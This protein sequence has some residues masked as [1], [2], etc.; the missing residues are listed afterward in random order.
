MAMSQAPQA[1][2]IVGNI[3]SFAAPPPPSLGSI[4]GQE[5]LEEELKGDA[6]PPS[7]I[8]TMAEP[9]LPQELGY[10]DPGGQA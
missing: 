9:S 3:P 4:P 7:S 5:A 6:A 8:P 10:L 2:V 1:E